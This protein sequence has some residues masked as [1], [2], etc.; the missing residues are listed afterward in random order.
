MTL[1]DEERRRVS[2]VKDIEQAQMILQKKR[3]VTTTV[4][5]MKSPPRKVA[6]PPKTRP[7]PRVNPPHQYEKIT[8]KMVLLQTAPPVRRPPPSDLDYE[9]KGLVNRTNVSNYKVT[10]TVKKTNTGGTYNNSPMKPP[11]M[12]DFDP[13][14]SNHRSSQ[15][16]Q[17]Q[18]TAINTG[19][20][21][22]DA[23]PL[24]LDEPEDFN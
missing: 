24:P 12:E 23:R 13:N 19:S 10:R 21:D 22:T 5:T 7:M 14:T 1:T 17:F 20:K 3:I 9:P 2:K 16:Y 15:N 18:S 11:P 6:S 4:R 8:S